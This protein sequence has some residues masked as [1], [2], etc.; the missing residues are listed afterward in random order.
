MSYVDRNASGDIVA[1]YERPQRD[2]HEFVNG[3][4]LSAPLSGP[5]AIRD[6]ALSNLTHDFG[7]GRVIQVRPANFAA[8]ESNIRNAIEEMTRN[9]IDS[10]PWHMA[11]NTTALVTADEL[12]TALDSA[13]DQGKSIWGEFFAAI[14]G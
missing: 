3:A 11:D 12:R 8:D 6:K 4:T 10:Q 9:N 14:G 2:G 5:R 13:Q 1:V 7:D